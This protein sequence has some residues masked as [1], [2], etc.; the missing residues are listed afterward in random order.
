M[1]GPGQ[2]R[3]VH[4][5][6]ECHDKFGDGL[7]GAAID[8]GCTKQASICPRDHLNEAVAVVFTDCAVGAAHLPA[9]D[10][11]VLPELHP[12][13]L[14]GK[15]DMSH[16]GIRKGHPGNE[17]RKPGIAAWEQRVAG[18]LECLPPRKV[19]ELISA[20]NIARGV[21]VFHI[22]AQLIVDWYAAFGV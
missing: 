19:S 9:A 14:L 1:D 18:G 3:N 7:T 16:L 5:L 22:R 2:V 15:P 21:N 13:L 10:L 8:D 20:G 12:R 6:F 17:V 11:Y 4:A